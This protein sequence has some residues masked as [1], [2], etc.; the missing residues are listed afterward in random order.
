LRRESQLW[1]EKERKGNFGLRE[2]KLAI[3]AYF[4]KGKPIMGGARRLDN[5]GHFFNKIN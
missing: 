5:G 4:E 1:A 3:A 2:E